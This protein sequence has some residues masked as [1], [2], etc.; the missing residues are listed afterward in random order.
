LENL[1]LFQ[2]CQHVHC[3]RFNHSQVGNKFV[4]GERG[5]QISI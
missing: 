3:N 1:L 5:L 2:S 4:S